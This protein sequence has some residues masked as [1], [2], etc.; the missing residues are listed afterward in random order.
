MID[1][2]LFSEIKKYVDNLIKANREFISIGQNLM[3]YCG[4]ATYKAYSSLLPYID[5]EQKYLA[6]LDIVLQE[7]LKV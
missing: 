4:D 6:R 2:K 3:N 1:F 7:I 5:N